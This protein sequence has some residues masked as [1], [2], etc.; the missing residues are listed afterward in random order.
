[1]PSANGQANSQLRRRKTSSQ[2]DTLEDLAQRFSKVFK[3]AS[4]L[5][6]RL[7]KSPNLAPLRQIVADALEEPDVLADCDAGTLA[8]LKA[9]L[10]ALQA[11]SAKLESQDLSHAEQ[12]KLVEDHVLAPY[13]NLAGL[14][15]SAGLHVPQ[16]RN[17][18]LARSLF[19]AANSIVV[20]VLAELVATQEQMQVVALVCCLS[21]WTMEFLKVQSDAFKRVMFK[22][23]GAISRDGEQHNINSATWY[24]S[25]MLI[26]S[27]LFPSIACCIGTLALGVGDPAAAL[28]GSK[29]GSVKLYGKKTLEGTLAFATVSMLASMMY[30]W[31]FYAVPLSKM[32]VISAAGSVSGAVA[33]LYC[34][35]VDDNLFVPVATAGVVSLVL[36]GDEASLLRG[37]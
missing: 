21:S 36:A 20:V 26:I 31:A 16:V 28:V 15:R 24:M 25:A 4:R 9:L 18:K 23:L 7:R 10:A 14:M 33:E 30:L 11:A 17:F 27:V 12:W 29:F 6:I 2:G 22:V 32:M 1:M 8:A 3:D 35:F 5:R 13:E 34:T 37:P 19:H